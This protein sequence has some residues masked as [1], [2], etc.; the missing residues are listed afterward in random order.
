[1]LLLN[2]ARF[3]YKPV[4]YAA[5]LKTGDEQHYI[6]ATINYLKYL[7]YDTENQ[8]SI[9]DRSISTDR[10]YTSIESA[11][12]FLA[13]DITTVGTFPKVSI[14]AE[15]FDTKSRDEFSATCHFEQDKNN[16]CLTSYTVKTESKG[17][18]RCC[19]L[20]ILSFTWENDWWW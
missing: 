3:C 18:K 16:I 4:L 8:K 17:K 2:D 20:N 6:K 10:L 7:V 5:Q 9:K 11:N 12:C 19:V 14:P 15:L 13:W 1:M